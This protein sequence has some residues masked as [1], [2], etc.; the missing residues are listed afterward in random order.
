[1]M[2]LRSG[3]CL[4]MSLCAQKVDRE[5]RN[6]NEAENPEVMDEDADDLDL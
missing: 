4:P 1:M 3:R 2:Q 6:L 5:P